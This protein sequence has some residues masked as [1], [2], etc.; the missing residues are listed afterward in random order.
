MP[1]FTLCV[2]TYVCKYVYLCVFMHIDPCMYDVRHD[3]QIPCT[4]YVAI[5][6]L[7]LYLYL[8]DF[9]RSSRFDGTLFW[10]VIFSSCIDIA[11]RGRNSIL[12]QD[13]VT[14]EVCCFSRHVERPMT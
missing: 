11:N 1:E 5:N 8:M 13:H 12:V 10:D 7:Y 2:R 9:N 4:R 3:I 6:R 14:V